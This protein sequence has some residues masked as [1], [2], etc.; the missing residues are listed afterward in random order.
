MEILK[1]KQLLRK[2]M[3]SKR[4]MLSEEEIKKE[5]ADALLQL[6]QTPEYCS[7]QSVFAYVSYQQELS[8]FPLIQAALLD[9]K[10]VAVPKVLCKSRRQ[11]EFY[12]IWDL[13]ELSPGFSGILEPDGNNLPEVPDKNSL[14]ILPGLSF[15]RMGKR[16]GYGGGFYDAYLQKCRR[17]LPVLA[18]YGY[19]F[20][21]VDDGVFC[22]GNFP[23]EE[24]DQSVDMLVTPSEVIYVQKPLKSIK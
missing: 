19:D 9:G 16:I 20:Q 24:H 12:R 1:Q 7:A 23:A 5:S 21:I 6:L 14:M 10:A 3:L 15:G 22:G 18:G 2:E 13:S 11:M 8:T 17:N 4:R